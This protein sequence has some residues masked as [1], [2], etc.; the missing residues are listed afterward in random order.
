MISVL[1]LCGF[2]N[3]VLF[4]GWGIDRLFLV[5]LFGMFVVLVN[6]VLFVMFVSRNRFLF[7]SVYCVLFLLYVRV[8]SIGSC[9]SDVSGV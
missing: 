6:V 4:D 5:K 1:L 8:V 3:S 9:I 7:V 2:R